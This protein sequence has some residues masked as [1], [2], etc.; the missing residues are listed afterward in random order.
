MDLVWTFCVSG[1]TRVL[2]L[3]PT[4]GLVSDILLSRNHS[5]R[6]SL[7]GLCVCVC[8]LQRS[9]GFDLHSEEG[10]GCDPARGSGIFW[11]TVQALLQDSGEPFPLCHSVNTL[12]SLCGMAAGAECLAQTHLFVFVGNCTN[13]VSN[14]FAARCRHLSWLKYTPAVLTYIYFFW[15]CCSCSANF[16]DVIRSI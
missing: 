10:S 5:T 12:L 6:F 8:I 7:H 14:L 11:R 3:T 4:A 16:M 2:A 15:L 1:V 13:S 9:R